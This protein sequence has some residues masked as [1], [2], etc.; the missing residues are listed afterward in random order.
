MKKLIALIITGSVLLTGAAFA[1]DHTPI[2]ARDGSNA[3]GVPAQLRVNQQLQDCVGDYQQARDQLCEEMQQLRERLANATDAEKA[4]IT[5]QIREKLQAYH[6]EQSEF[7]KNLRG[8]VREFR[9]ERVAACV[10]NP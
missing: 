8:M 10:T 2:R 4:E 6:S 5:A 7:R 3:A 1:Q 9:Q